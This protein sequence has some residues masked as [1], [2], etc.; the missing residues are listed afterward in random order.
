MEQERDKKHNNIA[1]WLDNNMKKEPVEIKETT[2]EPVVIE[3][4]PKKKR[5][6]K[7]RKGRSRYEKY[8]TADGK[9]DYNLAY[10]RE[11]GGPIYNTLSKEDKRRIAF[12]K[13]TTIYYLQCPVCYAVRHQIVKVDFDG[14][15]M[16]S[17]EDGIEYKMVDG[18]LQR[19]FSGPGD[20][21]LP[22]MAKINYGRYGQYAKVDESMAIST[23]K[24][25][26]KSLFDDFKKMLEKSLH[27][28]Q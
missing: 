18:V 17:H 5:K 25:L 6:Q 9:I 28:F 26:D 3:P 15:P 7:T 4:K 27:K 23:L 20:D 24:R 1:L 22:L 19:R 11:K 8:R 12:E 21:Y 10:S 14:K 2:E 16:K 13:G